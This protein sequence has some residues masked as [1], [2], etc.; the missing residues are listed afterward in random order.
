MPVNE[1]GEIGRLVKYYPKSDQVVMW[2]V[3]RIIGN[4]YLTSMGW[5]EGL[6]EEYFTPVGRERSL[7]PC[8]LRAI[9][10]VKRKYPG[11]GCGTH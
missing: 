2:A 5:I 1:Y 3:Q 4:Q 10:Y 9:K 7:R 8:I 6:L 11:K